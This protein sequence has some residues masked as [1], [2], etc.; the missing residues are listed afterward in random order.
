M[1]IPP[2][3]K[4]TRGTEKRSS[5]VPLQHVRFNPDNICSARNIIYIR[6]YSGRNASI[7]G[8]LKNSKG[9]MNY[10]SGMDGIRGIRGWIEEVVNEGDE[11]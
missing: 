6:V 9:Q 11:F 3:W 7:Q 8:T 2:A 5:S 4:R 10:R 1:P